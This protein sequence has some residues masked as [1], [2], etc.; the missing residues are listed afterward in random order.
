METMHFLSSICGRSDGKIFKT[1]ACVCQFIG[2][3]WQGNYLER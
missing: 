1:Y 3:N 2:E